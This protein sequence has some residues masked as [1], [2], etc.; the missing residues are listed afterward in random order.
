MSET[1]PETQPGE[2]SEEREPDGTPEEEAQE[3]T[4]PDRE[5]YQ[6]LERTAQARKRE[7]D[8][9]R[10]ELAR[11]RKEGQKEGEPDPLQVAN[12]R[13]V[14]A[15]A[16]AA[17]AS[18]GV[19]KDSIRDVLDVIRLDGID[20]DDSGEVDEEELAGRIDALRRALGGGQPRQRGPRV[21]TRDRG[22]AN[23]A[24]ADPDAAR[25]RRILGRR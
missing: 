3:W 11:V 20:V 18:A 8:E 14:R 24:P 1:E 16:R 21:D 25:Y 5:T 15:S 13:V 23:G 10:R 17:L 4:P 9:A 12:Q 2:Q 6:R 22:G 19:P 7:R